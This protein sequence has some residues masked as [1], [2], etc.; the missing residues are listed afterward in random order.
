MSVGLSQHG[1]RRGVPLAC[2]GQSWSLWMDMKPVFAV[3]YSDP[4]TCP[5]A[6]LDSALGTMGNQSRI[7]VASVVSCFSLFSLSRIRNSRL[8][9]KHVEVNHPYIHRKLC[10]Q[11]LFYTQAGLQNPP[12]NWVDTRHWAVVHPGPNLLMSR[13]LPEKH[14]LCLWEVRG[15]SWG[16]RPSQLWLWTWL[17]LH[18]PPEAASALSPG[19]WSTL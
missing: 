7:H 10:L 2:Q 13:L 6:I 16:P 4:A 12:V 18:L 11:P 17:G 14:D 19:L 3:L 9:W 1:G 5:R 15:Q 8:W